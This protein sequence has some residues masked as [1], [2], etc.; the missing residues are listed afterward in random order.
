MTYNQAILIIFNPA[1]YDRSAVLKAA[2]IILSSMTPSRE[3]Y[4][5]ALS[6]V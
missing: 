1:A 6:V 4:D 5:Q 2:S 3:A